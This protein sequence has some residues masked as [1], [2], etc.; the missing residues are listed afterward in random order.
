MQRL[1]NHLPSKHTKTH[2]GKERCWESL[3][4]LVKCL[5]LCFISSLI[6][7]LHFPVLENSNPSIFPAYVLSVGQAEHAEQSTHPDWHNSS[8]YSPCPAVGN[9]FQNE[10][11]T[12]TLFL[13]PTPTSSDLGPVLL[14]RHNYKS[15]TLTHTGWQIGFS[16]VVKSKIDGGWKKTQHTQ[17]WFLFLLKVKEPQINFTTHWS[18]IMTQTP[19]LREKEM[20]QDMET[21]PL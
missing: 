17:A 5:S 12:Y 10:S 16:S 13:K 11:S 7:L 6:L 20:E 8:L 15:V 19:P 1:N 2:G 14:L 18:Q 21:V 9:L 4:V 3:P